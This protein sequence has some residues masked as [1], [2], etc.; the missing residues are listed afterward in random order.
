MAR[1]PVPKSL[2]FNQTADIV[3]ALWPGQP[4]GYVCPL[5]PKPRILLAKSLTV[6]HAPPK[7][8]GGSAITLTCK[9]CNSMAGTA[10]DA[11]AV[12]A[13]RMLRF[14]RGEISSPVRC[15]L[16]F[17]PAS[18]NVEVLHTPEGFQIRGLPANTDPV[19]QKALEGE[20]ARL[21]DSK[22]WDGYTFQIT[23]PTFR[24]HPRRAAL[25]WLRAAY[26]VAF[27]AL[28]YS[29]CV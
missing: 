23:T 5:C 17:G 19:Q 1:S 15:R 27:A 28:G 26:V 8:L 2:W 24:F 29:Y 11:Q 21:T 20:L 14:W 25:A 3:Q 12:V 22:E 13:R 4:R 9:T 7:E 10:L 18:V 6:E 16:Q